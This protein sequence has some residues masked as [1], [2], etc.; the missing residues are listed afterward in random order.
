MI[1]SCLETLIYR[2]EERQSRV[3]TFPEL[4]KSAGFLDGKPAKPTPISGVMLAST[5]LVVGTIS[6]ALA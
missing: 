2:W 6:K 1:S 4:V 5:R 3:Y